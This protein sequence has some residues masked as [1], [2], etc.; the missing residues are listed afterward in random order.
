MTITDDLPVIDKTA[1]V[2]YGHYNCVPHR[3]GLT[4]TARALTFAL[5]SISTHT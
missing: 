4:F 5:V 1:K 2:T 3:G